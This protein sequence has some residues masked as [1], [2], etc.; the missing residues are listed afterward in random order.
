MAVEG[1][2]KLRRLLRRI[3]DD[4][5]VE[6]RREMSEAAELTEF[7]M[8]K[9]VP[10]KGGGLARSIGKKPAK[11]GLLW[12][13]GPGARGKYAMKV[14][15][16]RAKFVEFG[17]RPHSLAKG[18]SLGFPKRRRKK[19]GQGAQH[20]GSAPNPFVRPAFLAAKRIFRPR[21][22]AALDRALKRAAS[23]Q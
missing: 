19:Q 14:G 4:I 23:G 8:L 1:G 15:G 11:D 10:V 13:V 22:N 6:L 21:I 3:P 9:R 5:T 16:W 2:A 18:A 7:E 17:T 12:M 20:P